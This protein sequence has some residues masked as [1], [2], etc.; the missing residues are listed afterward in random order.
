[1]IETR[2]EPARRGL[3]SDDTGTLNCLFGKADD[4]GMLNSRQ[5][6][7]VK[8]LLNCLFKFDLTDTLSCR[9]VDNPHTATPLFGPLGDRNSAEDVRLSNLRQADE[10]IPAEKRHTTCVARQ[11]GHDVNLPVPGIDSDEPTVPGIEHEQSTI[12]N[13]WRVWHRKTSSHNLATGNVDQKTA[14]AFVFTPAFE[15][16]SLGEAGDKSRLSVPHCQP[17]EMA[18][19]LTN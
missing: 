4:G 5:H 1:M 14:I 10:R 7:D 18:A 6:L 2:R 3:G 8:D 16:V 13:P 12:V 15:R 19:V 11:L 9:Q 17:I